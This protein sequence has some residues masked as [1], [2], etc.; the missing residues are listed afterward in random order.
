MKKFISNKITMIVLLALSVAFLGF[1]TYMIARPIS[2]GMA[3]ECSTVYEGTAFEGKLEFS[4]DSTLLT[5]NSSFEEG[6][7]SYY[8]YKNGYIFFT[9]AETEIDYLKEVENINA[10]FE[11][12]I[13]LPFYASEINA[14]RLISNG[15][16]GYS[17]TYKCTPAII[18]AT[19]GGVTLAILLGF[20]ITSLTFYQR[21]KKEN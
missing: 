16:D 17:L 15:P 14:F 7:T 6:L 21:T 3:Y 12:A 20:S 11:S 13:N 18:F 5:Q 2:Y 4:S 10:D 8:F 1:Y 19:I 9:M